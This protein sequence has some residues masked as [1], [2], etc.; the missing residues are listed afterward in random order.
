[1]SVSKRFSCF[2]FTVI[3]AICCSWNALAYNIDGF[4]EIDY[5]W[6]DTAFVD[7]AKNVETDNSI[8]SLFVRYDL[9]T[10]RGFL[11]FTLQTVERGA[12]EDLGNCEFEITLN[13]SPSIII[14]RS[15]AEYDKDRYSL[16]TAIKDCVDGVSLEARLS[17]KEGVGETV[18]FRFTVTDSHADVSRQFRVLMKDA[19]DSVSTATTEKSDSQKSSAK[20]KSKADTSGKDRSKSTTVP[21]VTVDPNL[22]STVTKTA[23]YDA[24]QDAQEP[25]NAQGDNSSTL[26]TALKT[27][28]V[29]ILAVGGVAF[30]TTIRKKK[31]H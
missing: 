20:A 29:C 23:A 4:E 18:D 7:I 15:G 24:P 9:Q 25:E 13:N 26:K 17:F 22:L 10:N 16:K 11:Y 19:P 5:E 2:A 8:K 3:F 6:G 30:T 28:S 14:T 12:T 1:M 21:Y 27:V 31:K